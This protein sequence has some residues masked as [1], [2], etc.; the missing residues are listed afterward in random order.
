MRI[1]LV[2][3]DTMIGDSLRLGLQDEGYAVD[4]VRNGKE[5][6]A[7]LDTPN[8]YSAMLLD[9]RLPGADGITVL[10]TVRGRDATLPVLMLTARD[11]VEDR[12]LGLDSGADDYLVKP[13]AFA[14]L[15]ARTR[16]EEGMA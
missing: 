6:I 5:A 12:V 11:A 8:S 10:R 3:D 2:E 13:F 7:A 1:L 16:R 14:E 15:L 9:W 4:W